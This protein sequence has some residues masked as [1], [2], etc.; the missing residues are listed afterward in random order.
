MDLSQTTETFVSDDQSWLGSAH[1]TNEGDTV[2]LDPTTFDLVTAFPNGFIPSGVVVA[3]ITSGGNAGMYGQYAPGS[4]VN[5]SASI[6][7]D[8]TGGTFTITFQGE[9]TAAIAFDATAAQVRAA[10]ELLPGIN[11][12]DITVTGGPGAAGG[13]TPYVVT[14]TDTGQYADQ[15]APAI[16]TT[17]GSLTGGA[18][19][20]AVTTTPGG[21]TGAATDGRQDPATAR[22]LLGATKAKDGDTNGKVTAVIWHG[23]VIVSKL[24]AGNGLDH[25]ARVGGLKLVD[26]QD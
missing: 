8:A 24:P 11:V 4:V 2:T 21:G 25:A 19:T 15:D 7:V 26:F 22:L 10:L 12:G 18:G 13:A 6:A 1:G 20:A 9:T 17:A 14:F 23:Q 5:E 3:K 16:T